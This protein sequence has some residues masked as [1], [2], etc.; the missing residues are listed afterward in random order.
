MRNDSGARENI[1]HGAMKGKPSPFALDPPA[2]AYGEPKKI[3]KLPGAQHYEPYYFC[4]S[5]HH[6]IGMVEAVDWFWK[7]L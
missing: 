3:V 2:P 5:E 6:E 4:S 1:Q 7:Y